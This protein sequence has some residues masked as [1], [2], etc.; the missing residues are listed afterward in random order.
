[1]NPKTK[2][3]EEL[4]REIKPILGGHDPEIQSAVL[5]DLLAIF[6][7]GF[8]AEMRETLLTMM[9]DTARE[10]VPVNL[11]IFHGGED[12]EGGHA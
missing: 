9:S 12:D 10:L 4:V 8:P 2:L 11:A 7:A 1:M 3:V 6:L 5:T